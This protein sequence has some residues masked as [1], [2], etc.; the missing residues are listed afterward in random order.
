MDFT[1]YIQ[2]QTI[3]SQQR[4]YIMTVHDLGCDCKFYDKKKEIFLKIYYFKIFKYKID[5]SFTEFISCPEMKGLRER[6][7]WIHVDLPGQ[8]VGSQD[9][10]ISWV[11]FY[12][13]MLM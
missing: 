10:K 8:E 13:F 2:D 1:V 4:C 3:K 9:L 11:F 7:I 12:F 5:T 6:I